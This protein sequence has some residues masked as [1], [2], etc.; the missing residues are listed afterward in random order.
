MKRTSIFAAVL[1]LVLALAGTAVAQSA[2]VMTDKSDYAPGTIVTIT[3]SGWQAGETVTLS[4]VESPLIDTHPNLS[5]VADASGNIFN[6]QF[7]PDSHDV[8]I[9][10]TL[11]AIGNSSGLQAQTTFT[12]ASSAS[13]GDGTMTISPTSVVAGSAGN[14]LTFTFQGELNN[15][16]NF[17]AG[18]IITVTIPTGWTAPQISNSGNPGFVGN[19][20]NASGTTC[21]PGAPSVS[22][23]VITI[24]QTCHGVDT[25]TFKY[26]GATAQSGAGAATFTTASRDGSSG[27]AVNLA[28]SPSV[29][30]T[31]GPA[32]KLVFTSTA[33][34]VTAGAC[35]TA[36]TV[37]SQDSSGNPSNV[38]GTAE[39]LTPSANPSAG[40]S[41]YTDNTC[42]TA[43]T[44][45]NLT[46]PIG[47]NSAN[48]YFKDT[49][50]G[51]PVITVTGSG[52]FTANGANAATQTE[53]VNAATARRGQ[54]IV[55]SLFRK[56][57]CTL[58]GAAVGESE[59]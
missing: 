59:E 35:S 30:V 33:V 38:S 48:F 52:A 18:S 53:T 20:A 8:N 11:T 6:N 47:S 49:A 10:F 19:Q 13:S 37:Q 36:L 4:F 2:T 57:R 16:H 3:G 14:T 45:S 41:F 22:G 23:N 25:F 39:T 12:D 58:I 17:D 31:A 15:G 21:N 51:S 5:A 46:I 42:T 7:S 29:T 27:S 40:S 54:V 24:A 26:N 28:T 1:L 34:T 55:A 44:G 9:T 32:S 43:V 56:D 50:A